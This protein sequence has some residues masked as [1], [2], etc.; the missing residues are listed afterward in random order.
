M[1]A[2]MQ[3]SVKIATCAVIVDYAYNVLVTSGP[4][5]ETFMEWDL[6]HISAAGAAKPMGSALHTGIVTLGGVWLAMAIAGTR[7]NM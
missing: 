3:A 5:K 2:Q 4:L 6:G 7:V 1:S